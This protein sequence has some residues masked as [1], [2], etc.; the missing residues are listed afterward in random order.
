[1]FF[2]V[3]GQKVTIWG[4]AG[5]MVSAATTQLCLCSVEAAVGDISMNE[6]GCSPKNFIY[7]NQT[8][9]WFDPWAIVN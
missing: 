1:M 4:F 8:T 6:N 3:K 2:C 5:H 7:K 9:G